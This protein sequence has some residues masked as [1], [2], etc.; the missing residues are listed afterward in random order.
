MTVPRSPRSGAQAELRDAAVLIVAEQPARSQAVRAAL[1]AAGIEVVSAESGPQA[2]QQLLQRPIDL[3][4]L[5]LGPCGASGS[6]DSYELCSQIKLPPQTRS[7]PVVFLDVGSGPAAPAAPAEVEPPVPAAPAASGGSAGAG[8]L[9]DRVRA[10]HSGAAD[11]VS[12]ATPMPELIARLENHMRVGRRQRDL[13]REKAELM[14]ELRELRRDRP[15]PAVPQFVNPSDLPRGFILDGKYRLEER[16][17]LGGFGVVYRTTHLQ[18]QREVAVKIFRPLPSLS[19]EEAI[20]RF[21]QEGASASRLSHP[22][23]ITVLDSGIASGGIPYLAMELLVGRTLADELRERSPLPLSRCIQIIVPVCDVLIEAHAASIVHRDVK[24]DNVFLHRTRSGEVIKVLDFGIAKLLEGSGDRDAPM[25]TGGGA[26]VGTPTY[27][28]PERLRQG[29]YDGR[30]DVYSVGVMLYQ[31]LAGRPP[32][33]SAAQ[34]YLEIVLGHLNQPPPPLRERRPSV[35]EAVAQVVMRTLEKDPAVRPTARQLL[36]DLVRVVR[37]SVGQLDP[38]SEGQGRSALS[39]SLPTARAATAT[40]P[41]GV[42]TG[43]AAS[44][45]A[46]P[47]AGL[48]ETPLS[49]VARGEGTD[50]SDSGEH[51]AADSSESAHSPTPAGSAVP[52]RNKITGENEAVD[53]EDDAS[54]ISLPTAVTIEFDVPPPGRSQ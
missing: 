24:P 2:K 7:I 51:G 34:S 4:L 40:P 48:G 16:I 46:T 42:S 53:D 47:G 11:F 35:P 49:I 20:A 3:V 37:K 14:R 45:L 50:S 1:G 43:A 5:V 28:A 12:T 17:G 38:A 27:M 32:F 29:P 15:G 26:F 18:L 19:T 54:A 22:N 10:F 9:L 31:M 33:E 44:G 23:A 41:G 52:R 30:S 21:R 13:E 8:E 25:L 36:T 39:Q 6:M